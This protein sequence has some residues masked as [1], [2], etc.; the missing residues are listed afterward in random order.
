M[1]YVDGFL[2]AFKTK[3]L[4]AY[5]K[6]SKAAGKIWRSHGALDYKECIG[7]DVKIRGVNSFLK[8]LKCGKGET[9]IFAFIVYKSRAHRD[10]VNAK[11]MSDPRMGK[12]MQGAMPFDLKRM[13][14]GGFKVFVDA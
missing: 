6:M 5:T 11:V 4:K 9:P 10:K 2:L 14:M 12:A 8:L 13:W 1:A 3:N 7:D